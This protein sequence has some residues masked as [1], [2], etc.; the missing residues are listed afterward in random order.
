MRVN[1]VATVGLTESVLMIVYSIAIG[2]SI[3][4]TAMVARRVGEKRHKEAA[5]V[6][7][8][9]IFLAL[10][11]ALVIGISGGHLCAGHIKANGWRGIL[12]QR[13]LWLHP[14]YFPG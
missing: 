10:S 3:A 9:A 11:L 14:D 4:T 6:A 2:L 12:S 1:A 5:V 8:Q 13:R 7:V